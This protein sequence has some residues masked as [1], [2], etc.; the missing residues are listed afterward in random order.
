MND[1][2]VSLQIGICIWGFVMLLMAIGVCFANKKLWTDR[3]KEKCDEFQSQYDELV[4]NLNKK[5]AAFEEEKKALAEKYKH[6]ELENTALKAQMRNYPDTIRLYQNILSWYTK[7]DGEKI[8]GF[9]N[10][11]A[12]RF[13]FSDPID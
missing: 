1:V 9:I 8:N 7:I 2:S 6:F 11:E 3:M 12:N 10:E 13:N 4:A 5:K